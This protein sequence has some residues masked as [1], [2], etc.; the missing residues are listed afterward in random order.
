MIQWVGVRKSR[1]SEVLVKSVKITAEE[2]NRR[3]RDVSEG[4]VFWCQDG[5]H[6]KNLKDLEEALGTMDPGT[7]HHHT[8]EGRNDFTNWVRDVISDDKLAN[9]LSKAKNALDATDMVAQRIAFLRKK[10]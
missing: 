5:R 9:D 10:V 2:A 7:F 1:R 3:L 6:L 8:G 4:K